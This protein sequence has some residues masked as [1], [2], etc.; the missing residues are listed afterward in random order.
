MTNSISSGILRIRERGEKMKNRIIALLIVF[1]VLMPNAVFAK[2]TTNVLLK[3]TY[4][5]IMCG[6]GL[7]GGVKTTGY[8][9]VAK[10]I[11]IDGKRAAVI[12]NKINAM[13]AMYSITNSIKPIVIETSVMGP[14]SNSTKIPIKLFADSGYNAIEFRGGGQIVLGNGTEVGRWKRNEWYKLSLIFSPATGKYKLYINDQLKQT[15]ISLAGSEAPTRVGFGSEASENETTMYVDYFRVYEAN[16]LKNDFEYVPLNPKSKKKINLDVEDGKEPTELITYLDFEEYSDD[17]VPSTGMEMI[18]GGGNPTFRVKAEELYD[19]KTNQYTYNK[20]FCINSV[21]LVS[22]NPYCNFPISQELQTVVISADV[23]IPQSDGTINMFVLRDANSEFVS[24]LNADAS[25][26]LKLSDGKTVSG[27][28]VKKQ[29]TNVAVALNFATGIYRVYIN[30]ELAEDNV[31][32]PNAKFGN[33]VVQ[34]ARFSVP[35]GRQAVMYLDNVAVYTGEEYVSD[36]STLSAGEGSGVIT[37]EQYEGISANAPAIAPDTT[38]MKEN[39]K[40]NAEVGNYLYNYAQTADLFRNSLAFIQNSTRA[41]AFGK[42]IDLNH[43]TILKNGLL[44]VDAEELSKLMGVSYSYDKEKGEITYDD[45]KL[46]INENKLVCGEKEI[47]AEGTPFEQD[48]I[49]YVPAQD[50]AA[51]GLGKYYFPSIRGVT[52]IS[53]TDLKLEDNPEMSADTLRLFTVY[54]HYDTPSAATIKAALEKNGTAISVIAKKEDFERMKRLAEENELAAA[55]NKEIMN[56]VKSSYD[57]S[58]PKQEYDYA[59]LRMSLPQY[60]Q[61]LNLY[62]GYY[63]TGDKK[64][65]DRAVEIAK[66]MYENYTDWNAHQHFLETSEAAAAVGVFVEL[67]RDLAPKDV[68][69]KLVN[70]AMKY[71]FEP[72]MALYMGTGQTKTAWSKLVNNWNIVCSSGIITG[73]LAVAKYYNTDYLCSLV[74]KA[75]YGVGAAMNS[76]APSG[77]WAEGIGYWN[78][79]TMHAVEMIQALENTLGTDFR[80]SETPGFDVTGYYPMQMNANSGLVG[81]HD[82]SRTGTVL[83]EEYMWFARRFNDLS[84]ARLRIDTK[85][86]NRV[87]ATLLDLLWFIEEDIPDADEVTLDLDSYFNYAE[88]GTMRSGW[89]SNAVFA[90]AHAGRNQVPHGHYDM[91]TFEYEAFGKK[92]ACD[93]GVEKYNLPGGRESTQYKN[94]AEGHNVFIVNPDKSAGQKWEANGKLKLVE[95]KPK[96]AIFTADLTPAYSDYDIDSAQRGYRLADNRR[97]FTVQDEIKTKE[98]QEIHWLWHTEADVT[99][100][101][102]KKGVRLTKDGTYVDVYFKSNVDFNVISREALPY[103]TSPTVEGQMNN[104]TDI[105]N[106]VEVVFETTEDEV[107]FRATTIPQGMIVTDDT[108]L[109]HISDWRIEDGEVDRRYDYPSS[110]LL[111]GKPLEGVDKDRTSY[112]IYTDENANLPE[113]TAVSES[114]DIRIIQPTGENGATAQ[115]SVVSRYNQYN[116]ATYMIKFMRPATTALAQGRKTITP[117]AIEVSD[118]PQSDHLRDLMIDNDFSTSWTSQ[119]AKQWVVYDLGKTYNVNGVGMSLYMG[120]GRQQKFTVMV[121]NDNINYTSVTGTC[122]TSGTTTAIEGVSFDTVSARYVKINFTGRVDDITPGAWNNIT[123]LRVY[124]E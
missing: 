60:T 99:M 40:D 110:I 108:E 39:I 47:E 11:D 119:G 89:D 102:D 96:G 3:A 1:S 42:L 124:G 56:G 43:P 5:D 73:A 46:V 92:F 103:D 70:A 120:D 86:K 94:R 97:I 54:V 38:G 109:D 13:E 121:S 57:A 105:I 68:Q 65:V 74:E 22:K 61:F 62:W 104:M 21:G 118:E 52:V 112:I 117:A 20:Q 31:I 4:N 19:E 7:T 6:G 24:P 83:E 8:G 64:Y 84:L 18:N 77:A 122:V 113:V 88:V 10:A 49:L 71:T 79:T 82:S 2:T 111:D 85:K 123:E 33:A 90:F 55:W 59:N 15:R 53:D 72:A 34:H 9:N 45:V 58:L 91:G 66:A 17:A 106:L 29:K 50:I 115:V 48:S 80:L 75:V 25:G 44:Y 16:E 35:N 101:E 114:E 81:Y 93:M 76:Y 41:F 12:K 32:I 69:D 28:N 30:G 37:Y 87:G 67:F 98:E 63:M 78:F 107:I 116:V 14:D 95:S 51:R 23:Y 27:A 36:P 26:N 100:H